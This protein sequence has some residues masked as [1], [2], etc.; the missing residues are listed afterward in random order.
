[1]LQEECMLPVCSPLVVRLQSALHTLDREKYCKNL[2]RALGGEE[3]KAMM[4]VMMERVVAAPENAQAEVRIQTA[5]LM[6][7]CVC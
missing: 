2:D 3:E 4:M 6:A 7:P 1:M 5:A